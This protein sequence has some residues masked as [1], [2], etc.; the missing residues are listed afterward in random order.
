M[1][2]VR[3]LSN[4]KTS[5]ASLLTVYVGVVILL[6]ITFKSIVGNCAYFLNWLLMVLFIAPPLFNRHQG[7]DMIQGTFYL[8]AQWW[9]PIKQCCLFS[10]YKEIFVFSATLQVS[11][12]HMLKCIAYFADSSTLTPYLAHLSKFWAQIAE[13]MCPETIFPYF[14]ASH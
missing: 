1:R 4:L 14:L 6:A 5:I 8:L 2:T 3:V 11:C 12:I 7:K 13:G 9:N 10:H